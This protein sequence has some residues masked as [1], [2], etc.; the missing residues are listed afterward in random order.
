MRSGTPKSGLPSPRSGRKRRRL[1]PAGLVCGIARV[2]VAVTSVN[3]TNNLLFLILAA[4]ISTLLVSNFVSHWS[5]AGLELDFVL[6][7]HLSARRVF[8]AKILVRN[9]KRWTPSF[10]VRVSG[11]GQSVFSTPLYFPVLPG[12]STLEE[13]VDIRFDRRG[14]HREDGFEFSTT[15]PFG[16]LDRPTQVTLRRDILVYPCLDPQPGFEELTGDLSGEIAAHYRSRGHDFYRIRPYVAFESARHVDWKATAHTG[17]LQ[18]RE[19]AREE[20]PLVEI[21]FDLDVPEEDRG[22]FELAV[23]CCAY[24]AWHLVQHEARIRFHTQ[25]FRITVPATGDVYTILKY[26]AMVAPKGGD[27]PAAPDDE[28][29]FQIVFTAAPDRFPALRWRNTRIVSPK[30]LVGPSHGPGVRA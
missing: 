24:T 17:E 1:T 14:L 10:S 22:W 6:P 15:G 3:S 28:N 4:M 26:L 2:V 12:G 16:F 8:S 13:M 19:F 23:D 30:L 11:V 27:P 7:E 20:E 29:S 9:A 18:V 25:D 5:L 21:F